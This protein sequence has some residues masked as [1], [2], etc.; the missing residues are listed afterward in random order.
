MMGLWGL[1]RTGLQGRQVMDLKMSSVES[2]LSPAC[3]VMLS[4]CN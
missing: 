3:M 2:F 1:E 4:H